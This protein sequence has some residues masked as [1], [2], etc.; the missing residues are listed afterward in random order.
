MRRFTVILSLVSLVALAIPLPAQGII[1]ELVASH[2]S[3]HQGLHGNVD[4]PGQLNTR[5]NSFGRALQASGVYTFAEGVDQGGQIGF[6]AMTETFGLLPG[7]G[8]DNAVT[9]WVDNTRPN[10]KLTSDPDAWIWVYFVDDELFEETL[11]VYL[12]LYDLDHPAFE[13]CKNF[14]IEP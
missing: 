6:N 13:N 10:A 14:P 2:C 9:V 1:H 4:P 11:H 5:G 3:G 7:P 8:D 12:Q